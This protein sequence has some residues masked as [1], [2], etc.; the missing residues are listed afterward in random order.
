MKNKLLTLLC[1]CSFSGL[2]AEAQTLQQC[3]TIENDLHRLICYDK[4]ANAT[5]NQEKTNVTAN[6]PI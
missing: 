2:A 5:F 3:R 4:V 6:V 1:L